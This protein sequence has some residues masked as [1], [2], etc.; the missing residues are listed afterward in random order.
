MK[1]LG[2]SVCIR[3]IAETPDKPRK[4]LQMLNVCFS[5]RVRINLYHRLSLLA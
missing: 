4:W 5:L 1:W 2:D 3:E